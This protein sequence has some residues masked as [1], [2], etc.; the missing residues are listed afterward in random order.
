MTGSIQ[1]FQFNYFNSILGLQLKVV[2]NQPSIFNIVFF[3]GESWRLA[4]H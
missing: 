3:W 2:K 4:H 1:L